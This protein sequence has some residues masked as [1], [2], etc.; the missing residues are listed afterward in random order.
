MYK[1]DR[2]MCGCRNL[3]CRLSDMV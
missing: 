3:T 2:W 1:D